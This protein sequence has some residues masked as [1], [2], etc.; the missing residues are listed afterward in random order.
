MVSSAEYLGNVISN[1]YI[2]KDPFLNLAVLARAEIS[3]LELR[4]L[5][6][7]GEKGRVNYKYCFFHNIA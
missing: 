5:L 2:N 4:T 3:F 1:S 7:Q 6:P